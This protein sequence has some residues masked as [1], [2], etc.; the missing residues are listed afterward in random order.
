M[1]EVKITYNGGPA[2]PSDERI[3][4]SEGT[5]MQKIEH[6]G[7]SLR[8]WFA[9]QALAGIMACDPAL[10][11]GK[12]EPNIVARSCFELANAMLKAREAR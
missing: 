2:F 4:G 5:V 8:D 1:S 3:Y 9:G 7:M 12:Y 6:R 11:D 10:A